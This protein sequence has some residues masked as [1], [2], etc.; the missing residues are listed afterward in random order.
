MSTGSTHIVAT[1][2]VTSV[3]TSSKHNISVEGLQE[4]GQ[5][6]SKAHLTVTLHE[7]TTSYQWLFGGVG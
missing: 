2:L 1:G 3:M 7:W 5:L 6:Q 4:S